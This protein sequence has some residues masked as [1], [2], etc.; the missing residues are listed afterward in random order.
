MSAQLEASV[1]FYRDVRPIL[2]S[3][4]NACH[5][6]EKNKGD[7]DMT[8]FPALIKGGK[9]GHTIEPAAPTKASSSK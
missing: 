4:C 8:T 6:P 5:K 1:S 2:N 9:H 3:N 7:L